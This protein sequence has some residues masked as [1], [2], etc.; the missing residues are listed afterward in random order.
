[1]D[2]FGKFSLTNK[3][4]EC[5]R[6][7]NYFLCSFFLLL[8]LT[9]FSQ[10]YQ[11]EKLP[12]G[13]KRFYKKEPTELPAFYTK[14]GELYDFI[15][16]KDADLPFGKSVA[17]LVGVSDYQYLK[18][19]PAVHDDINEMRVFLLEKGGFDE[20][21]VLEGQSVSR[22][23]I[24]RY[25]KGILPNRMDKNDRLLFYYSG[26]GG[27]PSNAETGY[28]LFSKARK[29]AFY[30]ESTLQIA[31]IKNWF[32]ELS[33]KHF[34]CLLDCCSSGYGIASKSSPSTDE[35]Q[36][37]MI[38]TLSKE[39]SRTIITAGTHDEETFT[40]ENNSVFTWAFLESMDDPRTDVDKDGIIAINELM[41]SLE[42][43]VKYFATEHQKKLTPRKWEYPTKYHDGTFVFVNN[44]A[45]ENGIE[46]GTGWSKLT[47]KSTESKQLRA[48]D[49]YDK[50][51]EEYESSNPHV[52][53]GH[54]NNALSIDTTFIDAHF[55]RAKLLLELDEYEGAI[56]DLEICISLDPDNV[57]YYEELSDVYFEMTQYS[58]ALDYIKQAET[59]GANRDSVTMK[60]AH[61]YKAKGDKLEAITVLKNYIESNSGSPD[62]FYQLSL[63]YLELN[64]LDI[65]LTY[66]ERSLALDSTETIHTMQKANIYYQKYETAGDENY[67]K[68]AIRDYNLS[69]KARFD[70]ETS[71]GL[72]R[73]YLAQNEYELAKKVLKRARVLDSTNVD[74]RYLDASIKFNDE[75]YLEVIEIMK[76]LNSF[77]PDNSTYHELFG[78]AYLKIHDYPRAQTS[79]SRAI[80]LNP[81]NASLFEKRAVA[82]TLL[83]LPALAKE[84]KAR[85]VQLG[86]NVSGLGL[87]LSGSMDFEYDPLRDSYILGVLSY[88][89]K[90]YIVPDYVI[91]A[92]IGAFIGSLYCRGYPVND[93][94]ALLKSERFIDIWL[95][96]WDRTKVPLQNKLE[97]ESY[98]ATLDFSHGA[99][100]AGLGNFPAAK[101]DLL[102]SQYALDAPENFQDY[103][104]PFACVLTDLN[105]G[106][107]K[108]FTKGKYTEVMS[109]SLSSFLG[110]D[111]VIIEDQAYISGVFSNPLPASDLKI[112]GLG[113]I[114]G[115]ISF[116][117]SD[118]ALLDASYSAQFSSSLKR[119]AIKRMNKEKDYLDIIIEGD[120][121]DLSDFEY[122]DLGYYDAEQSLEQ[123]EEFFPDTT[124][125]NEPGI[126]QI[127]RLKIDSIQIAELKHMDPDLI[128]NK[129]VSY[130]DGF[131]DA[132]KIT[133]RVSDV[134]SELNNSGY[135]ESIKFEI[136]KS[137]TLN[138]L[139]LTMKEKYSSQILMG[140]NLNT[141]SYVTIGLGFKKRYISKHE[142]LFYTSFRANFHY[143]RISAKLIL[144]ELHTFKYGLSA[145]YRNNTYDSSFFGTN[146]I[147][148]NEFN[149]GA[150]LRAGM[151]LNSSLE[152]IYKIEAGN[153]ADQ[154]NDRLA[155][156]DYFRH[157]VGI[158]FV[159][160][161]RN[162]I[163]F[164]T[165]GLFIDAKGRLVFNGSVP[166]DSATASFQNFSLTLENSIPLSYRL[167]FSQRLYSNN[168]LNIGA[169]TPELKTYV[170]GIVRPSE[171]FVP[172]TGVG[173]MALN[174]NNIQMLEFSLNLQLLSN[175]ILGVSGNFLN[176]STELEAH[177]GD[178][179]TSIIG[180]ALAISYRSIVG[181]LEFSFGGNSQFSGL[182]FNVNLGYEF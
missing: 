97:E 173:F 61:I 111:P 128:R 119:E 93:I 123:R 127:E 155:S 4:L 125:G 92:G 100:Q 42:S 156:Y 168:L 17:F 3:N 161:S 69:N 53:I 175:I 11:I 182:V 8:S 112:A 80:D 174:A 23:M 96:Q 95:N 14:L 103:P 130:L 148:V 64:D 165:K 44:R 166:L 162:A 30:G 176:A 149:T 121:D 5:M 171:N 54:I 59:L 7:S 99:L 33:V 79:Y 85:S 13:V 106:E 87:I 94:R 67:L 116:S 164:A 147:R 25:I 167:S 90:N 40:N 27:N 108:V 16:S 177:F 157:L 21:Y 73:C 140:A 169:V 15:F 129:V 107:P 153:G 35:I 36:Q 160:D 1:M 68:Y 70:I 141:D 65:A 135:F 172:I 113:N 180:G 71:V 86:N 56:S 2:S 105:T 133:E 144:N 143:P 57:V 76:V 117:K 66:I 109:A 55:L 49:W 31:D 45:A 46:L 138:I 114:I 104:I 47:T 84:D 77:W 142:A 6:I 179:S 82:F 134:I 163:N 91:G 9:L 122:F 178:Q 74:L 81:R 120:D 78:D 48:K 50:A 52:A 24:E 118:F 32:K 20:V 12:G 41:A 34:L 131:S 151:G 22:S 124:K 152:A 139:R 10:P 37:K 89:E 19:L 115:V 83:G 170:G 98:S 132:A 58:S 75:E 145:D 136:I 72:I 146:R 63:L 18:D 60:K 38:R 39:G 51:A 150:F 110:L 29:G 158:G 154:S 181:P 43:K 137:D 62:A 101:L 102:L 26:H 159:F 28:M 88:L 126:H